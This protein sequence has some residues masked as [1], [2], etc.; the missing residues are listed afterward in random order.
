MDRR[1]LTVL[2]TSILLAVVVAAGFYWFTVRAAR[3]ST[4]SPTRGVLVAVNALPMG[5]SIK[6]ES[7]KTI[8]MPEN[9]FPKGGFSKVEEVADRPVMSSILAD[10][11]ILEG[12]LAAKGSGLGLAPMIAPGSRAVS[13]RVNDVVGVA[14][15]VLPGMRVDVLV[16]GKA[17]KSDSSVTK[18]VL[19]NILVL[20]AGQ[21]L[22]PEP[23]HQSIITPVV[24]LEVSPAQ[25]E[26]LTLANSEGHIQLVLRNSSD[27][28]L[29]TTS[30]SEQNE[31]YGFHNEIAP[32][33]AKPVARTK[34]VQAPR[35]I[36]A[37]PPLHV[38][39]AAP[40]DQIVI[41]RGNLKTVETVGLDPTR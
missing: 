24:T 20:S 4:K 37:V 35:T 6:A 39:E 13:V 14:G 19:Q 9:L 33:A 40:S 22:Q 17:P 16:T 32:R 41:I 11:P 25:A 18:T 12:R 23:K 30:G 34:P 2:G 36:A 10:E 27:H 1:F 26:I 7:V 15:F 38:K 31:L 8:Q 28:K 5:A 3:G 21:T 29:E